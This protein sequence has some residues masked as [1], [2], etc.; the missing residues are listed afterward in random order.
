MLGFTRDFLRL[1]S[2][3]ICAC[4]SGPVLSMS[5]VSLPLRY[6]AGLWSPAGLEAPD[7][8]QAGHEA[9]SS[10]STTLPLKISDVTR[11]AIRVRL[12]RHAEALGLVG[13]LSAAGD[14]LVGVANKASLAPACGPLFLPSTRGL[15]GA[16]SA[17][18]DLVGVDRRESLLDCRESGA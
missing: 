5:S 2:K 13:V 9:A 14:A 16:L 18:G 7:S 3:Q 1:T 15:N 17:W 10:S 4:K 11:L 6:S 12:F 8:S